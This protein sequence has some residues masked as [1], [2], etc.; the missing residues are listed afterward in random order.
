MLLFLSDV[1]GSEVLLILLVILIFFGPKSIPGIAKTFGKTI[2]QIKQAS[3]E[4]K[5]E[6]TKSGMEIKKELNLDKILKDTSD[7]IEREIVAP[8]EKE[9]NEVDH[10]LNSISYTP[11]SPI[12]AP[13]YNIPEEENALTDTTEGTAITEN[14]SSEHPEKE[15]QNQSNS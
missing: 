11:K 14:N 4:L 13:V 3:D 12:P 6:I 8:L 10:A 2:Y 9:V 5:S 7:E 15:N 1:A